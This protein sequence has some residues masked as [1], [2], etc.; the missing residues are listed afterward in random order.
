M[1]KI[2]LRKYCQQLK[3]HLFAVLCAFDLAFVLIQLMLLLGTAELQ[4]SS[5]LANLCDDADD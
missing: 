2:E 5:A 3:T 4:L 1:D